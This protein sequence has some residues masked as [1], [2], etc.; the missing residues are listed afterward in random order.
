MRRQAAVNPICTQVIVIIIAL[1]AVLSPGFPADADD[2]YA[3]RHT[4]VNM[5]VSHETHEGGETHET[6]EES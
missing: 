1:L 6:R 5:T 3:K 2:G 4:L